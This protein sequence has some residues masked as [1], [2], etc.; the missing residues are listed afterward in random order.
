[1]EGSDNQHRR[2]QK[3]TEKN[4]Q[5]P[6]GETRRHLQL[7]ERCCPS[8]EVTRFFRLLPSSVILLVAVVGADGRAVGRGGGAV[9]W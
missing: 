1:M 2:S 4:N 3:E 7:D 5:D 6:C 8:G 9:S